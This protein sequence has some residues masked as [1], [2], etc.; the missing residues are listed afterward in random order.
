MSTP[1]LTSATIYRP[2]P[3]LLPRFFLL[4]WAHLDYPESDRSPVR[5]APRE[6]VLQNLLPRP[7]PAET[8][9]ANACV[10][11]DIRFA[12]RCRTAGW[13][14]GAVAG[15]RRPG[16]DVRAAGCGVRRAAG[17]FRS[18]A[19]AFRGVGAR[20]DARSGTAVGGG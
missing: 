6:A 8:G 18:A 19:G 5:F 3:F 15:T 4:P 1:K 14:R 11:V 17:W 13:T 7:Q 2:C 12:R 10:V 16:A 9:V 20:D